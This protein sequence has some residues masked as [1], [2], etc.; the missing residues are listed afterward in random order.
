MHGHWDSNYALQDVE[1]DDSIENNKEDKKRVNMGIGIV[2]PSEKI[3]E[4]LHQEKLE[5]IRNDEIKRYEED[6][7]PTEDNLQNPLS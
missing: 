1:L 3:L 4:V 6:K 7:M 5:N 2:V